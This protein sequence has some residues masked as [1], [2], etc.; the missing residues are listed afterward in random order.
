MKEILHQGRFVRLVREDG[1]EYVERPNATGIV[2][3]VAATA[4]DASAASSRMPISSG[5]GS[6]PAGS[7]R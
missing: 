4:T 2:I 7:G 5:R 3:I 6:G 1:W